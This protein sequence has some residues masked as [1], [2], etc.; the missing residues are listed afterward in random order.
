V[1][2]APEVTDASDVLLE[3]AVHV[4]LGDEA[5]TPN[6]PVPPLTST[7]AEFSLSVK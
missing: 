6:D 5:V 1:S 2:E 4:Q 7:F 3:V